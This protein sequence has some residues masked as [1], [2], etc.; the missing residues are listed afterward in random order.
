MRSD[1]DKVIVERPR[2]GSRQKARKG[3]RK[4]WQRFTAEDYPQR[5]SIFAHK[6]RTK[7]FN[8]HLGPL[9]RYL[10]KQAGRPWNKVFA[11]ICKNLRCDSVVQSHVRDHLYDFVAVNV[12]EI[13]GVMCYGD[14]WKRGLPL[15]VR[16]W[17]ILYVCPSTGILRVAEPRAPLP[18]TN[19]IC[20]DASLQYHR[21]HGRWWE[22]R[23]RK[24]PAEADHCW[25]ALLGKPVV[26]CTSAELIARYGFQSYALSARPLKPVEA[27]AMSKRARQLRK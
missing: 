12:V 13:D 11:E 3:Y 8:E 22:V 25:D 15:D 9:R 17:T 21:I 20:V 24:V 1:M 26:H 7:F 23:L 16:R 18:P 4:K 6:G 2:L 10:R 5:E 27:R 14:G 19:R